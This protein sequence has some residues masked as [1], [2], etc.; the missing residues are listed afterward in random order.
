MA[1]AAERPRD[2]APLREPGD[3]G[4][5]D[6]LSRLQ[7][8]ERACDEGWLRGVVD[9][10]ELAHRGQVRRSGK[11]YI[12]HPLGV[13]HMLAELKFDQTSV[14][15]GLLH[16]VLEDTGAT[17]KDLASRFGSEIADLVDGVSKIGRHE[18]V[19][20]DEVQAES[21]R[22][23]ILASARDLRVIV[24]KLVDRLHNMLTLG[25]LETEKRKRISRET[26]EIYAPLAHRLGMSRIQWLLEDLAFQHMH[27]HQYGDLRKQLDERIKGARRTTERIAE[28]LREALR[29]TDIEGEISY[30]VKGYYSIYRKLQQRQIDLPELYDFL[31]F[32]IITVDVKDTYAALGVVHQLWH[33]IPGRFKDYIAMPKPNLYQSLHTT[34]RSIDGLPVEVQVRTHE[35]HRISEYGVASHWSY[36][37]GGAKSSQFEERMTWLRQLLEWQRDV[38]GTDEFL[39]NVTGDLF[40]DQVFVYTPKNEIRELPAGATPID[41]AYRIH[42]EIG[43]KCIGAKVNGR[44]VALNTPLKNGDTVEVLT[45]KVARGPSLDWL[46]PHLDYV[47]TASARQAIRSWFRHQERGT[48]IERGRAILKKELKRLS[49]QVDEIE[50]AR[51]FHYEATDDLYAAIG[52]GLVTIAQIAGRLS[53][54]QAAAERALPREAPD[55]PDAPVLGSVSVLGVGD[56]LTRM[57]EC[58]NPLPGDEIAGFITRNRGVTVHRQDCPNLRAGVDDDRLIPVS[59]GASPASHPTRIEVTALDRVGLLHDITGTVAGEGVNI[60]G[61]QT[62]VGDDGTVTIAFS[63]HVSSIEQLSRIFSRIEA[64]GVVYGSGPFSWNDG[65]INTRHGGRGFYWRDIDGH[66]M[67]VLTRD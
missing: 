3:V 48:N 33:P 15:V 31:A 11:P 61:S 13:A 35:M 41:F 59:W 26:L 50:V 9:F 16:D 17:K 2:P 39:E 28:R 24:V 44:L 53:A 18:Y 22:K 14:A 32:R 56:L 21:F 37:E 55:M 6:V 25:H 46:N 45:S 47:K 7:E 52:S 62:T 42:T 23:L 20:S 54:A 1:Q 12:S 63:L 27:P 51:W 57:G 19:H 4:I 66:L 34:V 49:A 65:K 29:K 5:D 10:A 38:S 67:E 40:R 8:N 30:R 36:K 43:H 58:C 64:D 60:S